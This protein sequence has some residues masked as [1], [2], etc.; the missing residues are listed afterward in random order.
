[1]TI[2]PEDNGGMCAERVRR[3]FAAF[4]RNSVRVCVWKSSDRWDDGVTGRTDIDLLVG[5]DQFARAADRLID[6]GWIPVEA[7]SWRSFPDVLDFIAFEAGE[8]LHLHLHARIVSGEKMIKSLRPPLTDL[9]LRHTPS[10]SYP[11]FVKA[12]LEFIVLILRVA[13]KISLL[14]IAGAIKRRSRIALYRYYIDEYH[15]LRRRC[16]RAEI[17][18][19]LGEPELRGLPGNVILA[20]YDDLGSLGIAGRRAIRR[21][22]AGWRDVGWPGVLAGTLWRRFLRRWQGVG[23]RMPFPGLSIA[24]CGPDGSGKTTL[25]GVLR[26]G[27]ARQL[28]VRCLYMGGNMSQPGRVRGFVMWTLWCP[29]LVLRKVAKIIR[30]ERAVSRIEAL[31]SGLDSLLMRAEKRRRLVSARK[32]LSQREIVLFER[33]PLFFPYGDDMADSVHEHDGGNGWGPDLLVLLDVDEATAMSRRPEDDRETLRR[34]VAA[35][36]RFRDDPGNIGHEVI[37]LDAGAPV[38]ANA[39]AVLDRM[40]DRLSARARAAHFPGGGRS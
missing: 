3:L 17:A 7:E 15:V 37:V 25:V 6:E 39:A 2:V 30:W 8:C 4:A 28:R 40:A 33:F 23:K 38:A 29:Y 19:L 10:D 9:Y 20:A 36:R 35:F 13:L 11:P 24:V 31:Y 1:V 5:K 12:E 32:I 34:K 18:R 27:I 26:K 22:L 21:A 14:D 16:D